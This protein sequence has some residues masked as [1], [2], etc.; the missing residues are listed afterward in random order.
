MCV[1]ESVSERER[2]GGD[3]RGSKI[4]RVREGVFKRGTIREERGSQREKEGDSRTITFS[5]QEKEAKERER[6]KFR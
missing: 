4:R 3:E 2:R 1:T 6:K 5:R